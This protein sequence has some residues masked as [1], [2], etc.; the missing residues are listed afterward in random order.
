M[1][2]PRH[3]NHL[4]QLGVAPHLRLLEQMMAHGTKELVFQVNP[5]PLDAAA[6]VVPT[7][8]GDRDSQ[9]FQ[10]DGTHGFCLESSQGHG[11][12]HWGCTEPSFSGG[13]AAG[14]LP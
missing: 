4:A 6:E 9:A 2:Q 3:L 13:R 11:H 12:C 10:T 5:G 1:E 14:S 8:D 7:F